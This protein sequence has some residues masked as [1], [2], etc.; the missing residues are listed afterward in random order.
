M[1]LKSNCL[2]ALAS[3]AFIA[4]A[5]AQEVTGTITGTLGLKPSIWYVTTSDSDNL[6]GWRWDGNEVEVRLVGQVRRD[7]TRAAE[8]TLTIVFGLRVI[9]PR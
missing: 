8:G 4:P 6:S 9:R 7:S 1:T 5:M 3:L 2:V